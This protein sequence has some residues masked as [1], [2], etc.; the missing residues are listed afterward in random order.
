[1]LASNI[2][3]FLIRWWRT[4]DA[5]KALQAGQGCA[6]SLQDFIKYLVVENVS[7]FYATERFSPCWRSIIFF[8]Y[9]KIWYQH[10]GR[11]QITITKKITTP[12]VCDLQAFLLF[13]NIKRGFIKS[14]KPHKM[15]SIDLRIDILTESSLSTL[16]LH[17]DVPVSYF[18]SFLF[19]FAI[20]G[21]KAENLEYELQAGI[22]TTLLGD[23]NF[24]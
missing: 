19:V 10:I 11:G 18:A 5:L 8:C 20:E 21:S 7:Y 16:F 23:N 15:R 17:I 1:M 24:F 4:I 14:L 6:I 9:T 3:P 12:P 2:H 22:S 13:P